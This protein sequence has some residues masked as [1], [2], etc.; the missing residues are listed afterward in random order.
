MR[1]SDLPERERRLLFLSLA[2]SISTG[3]GLRLWNLRGQVMGGDE[4]HMVRAV[5]KRTL[6]EILTT[7]AVTDY[8]IPLTAFFR[9]L[10]RAGMT[11]SELDFRLPAL[12]CGCVAL[13]ALP[14]LFL[15]K[16]DRVT[17]E[18]SGWLMAVS[19]SLVLYSRIARSYLPMLLAGFGA[20][21]AFEAWW[22][23][24]E[25][26]YAVLYVV[27][28]G[29][30]VWIHLGAGPF[31]A[32]PFLFA[33]GDLVWTK[34]DRGRKLRGLILL[35]VG[36]ALA[37]AAF[38]VPA[39]VSLLALIAAKRRDQA[40]PFTTVWDVLSLQAG[41]PS[42]T[43][44]ALFWL[45]ALAGLALLLRDRPRTGL[46]TLTV[47]VGH[48]AGLLILSP[49]GL[50][51]PVILNRYL[52]PVLPFVLLWFAYGLGRLWTRKASGCAFWAAQRYAVRL[53]MLFLFWTGPFLSPGFRTSSFMHHN[54]FV[55]FFAPRA[56]LPAA[57]VPAIYRRLPRGP[58]L[59]APWPP[60]W[61]FDRSFYVYQG[62][63]GRRVLVSAP[64]D[65]P[66][67]PGIAFRNEVPP[68]PAA[69][70]ASPARTLVVH[71]RLAWEEDRV[72]DPP[73]RPPA[74]RMRPEVRRLYRQAGEQLAARLAREWGPPDFADATVRAWDLDR[75]R[76]RER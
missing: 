21:F 38:L 50:A 53:A 34:E 42:T 58:V 72:V 13:Y 9:L 57:V 27:L 5:V 12:L 8:S 19:P 75:V 59:E 62:I 30:A 60:V 28:G 49:L 35:G 43:I 33:L 74:R 55:G 76:G 64:Y 68:E 26:R 31:V 47:A 24:G 6:P 2:G 20:V 44:T 7:Y 25:R 56:T 36:L 32:A 54:D 51:Q 66:R 17:V 63:H 15:G 1:E 18:L 14:R 4:L 41:T 40:V 48:V 65:V 3:L 70:L 61:D 71:V 11:L 23:T 52:L 22:R 67:D 10:L 46:F 39:R 37:L 16:V 45:A 69:L 73:G 29:L